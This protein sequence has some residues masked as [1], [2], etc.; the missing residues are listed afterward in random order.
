MKLKYP[1]FPSDGAPMMM[2]FLSETLSE[3]E[4]RDQ[5]QSFGRTDSLDFA[6]FLHRATAQFC[7]RFVFVEQLASDLHD[8]HSTP[9]RPQQ[10]RDQ[11]H[12]G[13]GVGAARE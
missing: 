2:W 8:I 10:D 12:I 13:Q 9:A 3:I 11:F 1:G 6:E 5:L 7:E 4:R